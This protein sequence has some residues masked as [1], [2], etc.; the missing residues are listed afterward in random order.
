MA[1]YVIIMMVL[2][3]VTFLSSNPRGKELVE[4][5]GWKSIYV[6]LL[7][8][9]VLIHGLRAPSV[10]GD[11]YDNYASLYDASGSVE[12]SM[13]LSYSALRGYEFGYVLLNKTCWILSSGNLHFFLIVVAIIY[14]SAIAY[15][16]S[17]LSVNRYVG[18]FIFFSSYMYNISMNN[19]RSSLALSIICF[20]V[21]LLLERKHFRFALCVFFATFFHVTA[22]VFC[23]F[24]ATCM[25]SNRRILVF[26]YAAT[27]VF[28]TLGFDLFAKIVNMFFPKY[29]IYF[30]V[31]S[32]GGLTFLFFL[33]VL[34]VIIYFFSNSSFWAEHE[35]L[36]M[37]KMLVC[38]VVL[39]LISLKIPYFSRAV[40]YHL[41]S[42]PV[43][44]PSLLVNNRV[45]SRGKSLFL[46]LH[47]KLGD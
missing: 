40:Y 3:L 32:N 45:E 41:I 20:G 37:F 27:S 6:G 5:Q 22:L 17:K 29:S 18:L 15:L 36:L 4:F 34:T 33:I 12:W 8:L 44:M 38:G 28:F 14:M 39:Q 21:P 35:N 23:F 30:L 46:V 2:T 47:G 31:E 9:L 16:I 19:I 7:F 1:I 24:C 11:L 25:I 13:L 10:G 26:I 43:L 42:L